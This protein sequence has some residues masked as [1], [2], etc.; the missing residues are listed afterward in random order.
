MPLG[1]RLLISLL[2]SNTPGLPLDPLLPVKATGRTP[3]PLLDSFET[4]FCRRCVTY[5]CR[6]VI[7]LRMIVCGGSRLETAWHWSAEAH[8]LQVSSWCVLIVDPART[9]TH[10]L[11]ADQ[12]M[13]GQARRLAGLEEDSGVGDC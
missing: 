12:L 5:D 11:I 1:D 13:L 4:L 8:P 2:L 7:T 3:D 9:D 6:M 10:T